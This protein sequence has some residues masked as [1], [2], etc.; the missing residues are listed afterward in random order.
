MKKLRKKDI[1][2]S[3]LATKGDIEQLRENVHADM[4]EHF[5]SKEELR[6]TAAKLATKED[7]KGFATKEDLRTL[8]RRQDQK[9]QELLNA[10]KVHTEHIISETQGAHNDELATVEGNK[11][12]PLKWKSLPRRLTAVEMDVEKIKDHLEIS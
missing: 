12:A 8:E 3:R 4:V 2:S 11:E 1:G 10:F 6:E 7:L 5:V 9:H